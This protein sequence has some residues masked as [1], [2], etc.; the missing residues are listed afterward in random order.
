MGTRNK[1]R[2]VVSERDAQMLVSHAAFLARVSPA[3]ARRLTAAF[4]SA[5]SS[6]EEMPHRCPRLAGD[7]ISDYRFLLFEKRYILVFQI[8][9]DTVYA[10]YVIDCRQDYAWLIP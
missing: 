1:Y 5:A 3:A 7:F 10:D 4:E 9:G 8:E 6:L 2:V